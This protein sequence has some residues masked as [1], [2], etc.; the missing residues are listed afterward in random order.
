MDT[1]TRPIPW[2]TVARWLPPLGGVVM[3]ATWAAAGRLTR[4]ASTAASAAGT[5]SA[6]NDERRSLFLTMRPPLMAKG[7]RP[8][9]AVAAAGSELRNLLAVH[10]GRREKGSPF[11]GG[12]P[13][14]VI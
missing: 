7:R 5:S 1:R 4:S 14:A 10:T 13:H 6:P 12:D 2:T 11:Q 3:P 9:R 8:P